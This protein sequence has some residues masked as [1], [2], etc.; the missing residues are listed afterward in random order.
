MLAHQKVHIWPTRPFP[1]NHSH[2]PVS[3]AAAFNPVGCCFISAF[4]VGN[5]LAKQTPGESRTELSIHQ[6][7]SKESSPTGC[8]HHTADQLLPPSYQSCP[9]RWGGERE[10]D[11]ALALRAKKILYPCAEHDYVPT[12]PATMTVLLLFLFVRLTSLASIS[13]TLRPLK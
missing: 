9:T 2:L 5:T 1:Q 10:R 12:P 4:P 11:K 6:L 13:R 7:V 8:S 3:R